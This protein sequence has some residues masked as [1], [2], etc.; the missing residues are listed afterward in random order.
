MYT[1]HIAAMDA[2]ANGLRIPDFK[3][4]MDWINCDPLSFKNELKGKI[5][6]LDFWTYCCINCIH[7]LPILSELEKRFHGEP[8]VFIGV[9]CAKFSNERISENI[10]EAI[11]RYEITHPVVNDLGFDFWRGLDV[12]SW[13]T[14]AVIGPKGNLLLRAAGEPNRELLEN[15]IQQTLDYYSASEELSTSPLSGVKVN[16]GDSPLL[17]PA[18]LANDDSSQRLFISDSNHNRIIIADYKG[19]VLET[20]GHG[21]IG[22]ADGSFSSAQFFRPQGIVY[23]QQKLY[24]ADTENHL[25]READLIKRTVGTLAGTGKQGHDRVGGE[26]GIRQ[27]LSSPWDLAIKDHTLYIAMAGLHQIW[28]Y[29]IKSGRASAY[30]GTGAELHLNSKERRSSAWAQP[31][32]LSIGL[33]QLFVADSE[34]S[35]IR[36]IDLLSGATYTLA[37]GDSHHPENLFSFG[38]Q[39]GSGDYA[40]LQHPLGVIWIEGLNRLVAADTYN[41]RLKLI[42]PGEHT[43]TRWIGSGSQGKR[44]GKGLEAEFYE[45]SGFAYSPSLKKLFVADS[46]NHK[47]REIDLDTLEVKSL[48]IHF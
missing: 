25:L 34:S 42:D 44:N 17:Y 46:N 13:P 29:D 28:T 11:Q 18:K 12:S 36:G 48:S 40:K 30:A 22:R 2:Q 21:Q 8:V 5:V 47:I 27:A 43:S 20:I 19:K 24:I 14:I 16:K 39:D 35:T 1:S 15:F 37:G 26:T 23:S 6:I 3:A 33:D 32:G 10:Q 41:H 7:T 9:H 45:P 4:G 31:S 38:D